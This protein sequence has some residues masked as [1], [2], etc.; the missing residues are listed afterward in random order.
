MSVDHV[1]F[2]ALRSWRECPEA[3]WAHRVAHLWKPTP[4]A[5]MA[6]GTLVEAALT[7]P[8]DAT[9]EQALAALRPDDRELL[10][11]YAGTPRA[12]PA[13]D[14]EKALAWGRQA[15]A[16]PRVAEQLAGGRMQVEIRAEL[17][18]LV[19]LGYADLVTVADRLWDIK[20]LQDAGDPCALT[21]WVDARPRGYY[22][23]PIAAARYGYQLAL[24][25]LGL[26]QDGQSIESAGLI[27][28]G[29]HTNRD[30]TATPHVR[31]PVWQDTRQFEA[32]LNTMEAVCLHPW[33]C[34]TGAAIPAL[35]DL[36]GHDGRGLP[37]CE[38][39]DWCVGHPGEPIVPYA[40]PE[41]RGL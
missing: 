20:A 22:T 34:D 19:W 21:K 33:T 15:A 4:T 16:I 13:A 1:S 39:C 27:I 12:R 10:T 36:Y 3:A 37:R 5:A 35:P 28:V 17:G 18:G 14:A 9:A 11:A 41:P 29:K 6:T 7:L 26:N 24:Y 25:W 8:L 32:Y 40:D 30:G 31:M 23:T 2:S 38:A